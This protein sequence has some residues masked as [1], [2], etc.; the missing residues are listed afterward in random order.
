MALNR[1]VPWEMLRC[2]LS[3]GNVLSRGSDTCRGLNKISHLV[4]KIFPRI[5]LASYT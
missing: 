2:I 1:T 3:H 5:N 4:E